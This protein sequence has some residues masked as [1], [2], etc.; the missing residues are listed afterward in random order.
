MKEKFNI[1]ISAMR[2]M[3][4]ETCETITQKI[5]A[6]NST[7]ASSS[8]K[9]SPA[10]S[11]PTVSHGEERALQ[12]VGTEFT[13]SKQIESQYHEEMSTLPS[14]PSPC[15]DTLSTPCV[16]TTPVQA[17]TTI[18]SLK[19]FQELNAKKRRQISKKI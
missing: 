12:V 11:L 7:S 10:S 4:A 16:Q 5:I 15:D 6:S 14:S 8:E 19:V 18:I 13:E 9:T 2:M 3:S 1:Q 17:G